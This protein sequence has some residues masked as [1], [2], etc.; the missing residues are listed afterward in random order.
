MREGR[1]CGWLVREG[2]REN[3]KSACGGGKSKGKGK[4]A[5]YK[6]RIAWG[7]FFSFFLG[8][9][10]KRDDVA[11]RGCRRQLSKRQYCVRT[12]AL[13]DGTVEWGDFYPN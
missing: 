5:S 12:L 8:I 3:I 9:N 13:V 7:D 10:G 4:G 6:K 1:L 2:K 11:G